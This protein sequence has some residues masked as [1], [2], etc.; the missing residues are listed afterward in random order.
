[1]SIQRADARES[2]GAETHR[3]LAILTYNGSESYKNNIENQDN[4]VS[5]TMSTEL[6]IRTILARDG[7]I[8]SVSLSPSKKLGVEGVVLTESD[9]ISNTGGR[10]PQT[11][12]ISEALVEYQTCKSHGAKQNHDGAVRASLLEPVADATG[13]KQ[14]IPREVAIR[15]LSTET[16]SE[17]L[18]EPIQNT[19]LRL[20]RLDPFVTGRQYK[21]EPYR[22]AT[23]SNVGH[24]RVGEADGLLRYRGAVYVPAEQAIRCEII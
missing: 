21:S 20:Q 2:Q 1:M 10:H 18:S 5:Y 3:L 23:G 24:W 15:L 7:S 9:S 16:G 4:Y 19:L 17:S 14:C 6:G 12:E 22:R 13:Y 8:E 11:D